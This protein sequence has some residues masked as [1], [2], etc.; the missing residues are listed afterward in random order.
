MERYTYLHKQIQ[1]SSLSTRLLRLFRNFP[2]SLNFFHKPPAFQK[3]SAVQKQVGCSEIFINLQL[4]RN[5]QLSRN[6]LAVQ[7]SS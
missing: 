6:K 3:T 4:F 2:L 5:H 1:K 7:K